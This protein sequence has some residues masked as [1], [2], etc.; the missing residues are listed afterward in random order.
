[1]PGRYLRIM[2]ALLL[3]RH[4]PAC[5]TFCSASAYGRS[6]HRCRSTLST[7]PKEA[8]MSCCKALAIRTEA[9]PRKGAMHLAH[10]FAMH[11]HIYTNI[12]VLGLQALTCDPC[13][14]LDLLECGDRDPKLKQQP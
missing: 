14:V 11:M 8:S 4:G 6:V 10:S 9:S 13:S 3:L 1:M 2:T 12:P 5:S 7:R